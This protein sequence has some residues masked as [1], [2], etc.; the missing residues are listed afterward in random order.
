[1]DNTEKAIQD[2]AN[3]AKNMKNL[4]VKYLGWNTAYLSD[5]K[6]Y[7]WEQYLDLPDSEDIYR[8]YLAEGSDYASVE[9]EGVKICYF[10]KPEVTFRL[11]ADLPRLYEKARAKYEKAKKSME[12]QALYDEQEGNRIEI[13]DLESRILKLRGQTS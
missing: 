5:E 12:N 2:F 7:T 8:I 4:S 1:M 11:G 9:M 6:I 13:A 3:L 10:Q